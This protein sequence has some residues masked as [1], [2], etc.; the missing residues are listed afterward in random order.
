MDLGKHVLD[1]ELIDRAGRR[2]GRVDDLVIEIEP[3]G[4]DGR[5]PSPEVRAIV[6][7][8]L[9]L[10]A[11]MS[12]PTRWLARHMYR[13]LGLA[14]PHPI[15]IPWTQV[16]AIDVTVHVDRDRDHEGMTALETAVLRRYIGKLPGA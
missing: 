2:A 3:A 14:D 1:K 7:G 9:A 13:L 5:I 6:S 8:P 4:P 12:R 15:E 10:R 16:T 11:T